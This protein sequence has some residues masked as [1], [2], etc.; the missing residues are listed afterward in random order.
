MN[1]HKCVEGRESMK[2]VNLFQQDLIS[3]FDWFKKNLVHKKAFI[4]FW[5]IFET[6]TLL[7]DTQLW[8]NMKH[9]INRNEN[10][11]ANT[12][13]RKKGFRARHESFKC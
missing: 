5:S 1:Y 7:W 3:I 13:D 2:F 11:T 12:N 9:K 4:N 10:K 6:L 8:Q